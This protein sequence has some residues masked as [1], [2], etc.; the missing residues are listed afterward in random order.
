MDYSAHTRE[1]EFQMELRKRL[2]RYGADYVLNQIGEEFFAM[3]NFLSESG[4]KAHSAKF[5]KAGEL[6]DETVVKIAVLIES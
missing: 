5:K 3:A 6:V 1:L 2:I 4:D